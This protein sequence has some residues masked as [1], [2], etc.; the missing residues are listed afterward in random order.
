MVD[1]NKQAGLGYVGHNHGFDGE[2]LARGVN[3]MN[4]GL[5]NNQATSYTSANVIAK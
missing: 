4:F 1:Q 5:V 3:G 2:L